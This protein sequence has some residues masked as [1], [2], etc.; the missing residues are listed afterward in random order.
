MAHMNT[1]AL[2]R[3][4]LL[5]DIRELQEKPYPHIAFHI[6]D[7]NALQTACLVLSPPGERKL[8]LTIDFGDS[9][10]LS[11]PVV[12]IQSAISHPNVFNDYICASILNTAEGYTSAYTL[13]G[14]CIQLLSFFSS[15][16]IEQMHGN[17]A[18][19]R[20]EW[21][22]GDEKA[23]RMRGVHQ[24]KQCGFG[25]PQDGSIEAEPRQTDVAV[26][27][28]EPLYAVPMTDAHIG[29]TALPVEVLLLVCDLL[30]EESLLLAAKAWNGF[31]RVMRRYNI[32][33]VREMQ[34]FTLKKGFNETT[35]GVGVHV[36]GKEIQSEFDLIS[37]EAFYNLGVR[38]SVQ[39]LHFEYW[40]PLPISQMHWAH[41]AKQ[42]VL[43]SLNRIGQTARITGPS[44]TILYSFLSDITVRL[45]REASEEASR[46]PN[47]MRRI[48]SDEVEAKSTLTHASEKA[49]ES[50]FHLYHLLLCLAI[51][52]PTI[53]NDANALI[54]NFIN[55]K[56]S[57]QHAPNLGHLL[58]MVLISDHDVT[59]SLTK[60]IIK[61]AITRNVVWMLDAKGAN[62][63]ELSF[64]ETDAISEYRLQKTFDAGKTSYRLLMFAKEMQKLVANTA[65]IADPE[66]GE[67]QRQSIT[68]RCKDLF[69][70]HGAPP[71]GAAASLAARIREIQE[72]KTFRGFLQT[73][74]MTM[75][76]AEE[77][78]AF[79]RR[80]LSLSVEKGYSKW[81]L[82]Q[83]E[84]LLM[85]KLREPQVGVPDGISPPY[86]VRQRY[87]FFPEDRRGNAGRGGREGQ[88]GRNDRRGHSGRGGRGRGR[89]RGF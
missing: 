29:L 38:R 65:T 35:L 31:G 57:K 86:T 28:I 47:W 27:D 89:G 74:E 56:T 53:V 34:C 30:D 84:A 43:E 66:T 83:R 52:N 60:A 44:V 7:E 10:P 79:L 25:Q 5:N 49:I 6:H 75:P 19:S 46:R 17:G 78:T 9:Y 77:F 21:Q 80:T 70:R 88:A 62:M 8:H 82:E 85:R 40:L 36:Q 1:Q 67:I 24:C 61:E 73:M 51:D 64:L 42:N 72:V 13:K 33:H 4:R 55:C 41:R 39:G 59:E 63:P 50:Y 20:A 22:R 37:R 11:P 16:T 18:I 71:P 32:L 26:P 14:I 58:I 68:Q 69:D 81:A 48:Y 2:L 87:T 54:Q 12:T 23:I 76:S 3:R 45:S 15:D